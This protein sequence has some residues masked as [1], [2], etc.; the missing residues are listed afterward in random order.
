MSRLAKI[1]VRKRLGRIVWWTKL[2][3]GRL[4]QRFERAVGIRFR[5]SRRMLVSFSYLFRD[6]ADYRERIVTHYR[7]HPSPLRILCAG[8]A[9]GQEPYS[10]AILCHDM[11]IPVSVVGVDLSSEAVETAKKGIYDLSVEKLHSA[12]ID[13][14]EAAGLMDRYAGYFET[15]GR[16]SESR[17]VVSAIR[18]QVNFEVADICDLPWENEFDFVICRKILYYLPE[19]SRKVALRTL[20]EALKRD[21]P[22]DH[23]IFDDFTRKQAFFGALW[24]ECAGTAHEEGTRGL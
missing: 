2:A 16:D 1:A 11:G 21:L 9:T 14:P 10:V 20:L 18:Q 6:V 13:T 24:R 8:S 7:L 3:T 4:L 15:I 23:I 19:Q 12:D 5:P 22:R 17:R